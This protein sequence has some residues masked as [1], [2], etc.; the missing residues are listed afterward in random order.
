MTA[1]GQMEADAICSE[2]IV[3]WKHISCNLCVAGAIRSALRHWLSSPSKS[4]PT[5]QC[6][7]VGHLL[8]GVHAD[9]C[10]AAAATAAA[11]QVPTSPPC[12][13]G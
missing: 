5:S 11:T 9:A 2:L 8:L 12:V 1:P 3:V 6:G 10:A 4:Q 7:F 13:I